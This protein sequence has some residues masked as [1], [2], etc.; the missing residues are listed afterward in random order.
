MSRAL[1]RVFVSAG[2]PSGDLHAAPV[3]EALR[4]LLPDV[5]VDAL[6]GPA[7]RQAGASIR[8]PMERYTVMGFFE[9][10]TKIHPHLRML[11]EL[12]ADFRADRYDLVVLVDYPG[13]NLRLAEAAHQAGIPTLYYIAPQLWA[14]R[15]GRA[16]RLGRSVDRLAAILPFEPEFFRGLGVPAEFVGHPLTERKWPSR[17]EARRTLGLDE[18]ERVLAVF[19][20]S[21]AQEVDRIWPVFREAAAGLLADGDCSRVLVA[22]TE[23]GSYPGAEQIDVRRTGSANLLAAADAALVKSGTT[24]LEA[25]MTGTPM[26]V[27]YRVN[28]LTAAIA[29]R[30]IRV[31]WIS[32]VNLVAERSVVPELL[33]TD[34]TPDRLAELVRPLLRREGPE[35]KAQCEGLAEVRRRLGQP[36]AAERVAAL[37]MELIAA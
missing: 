16:R 7:L 8:F 27:A 26:V 17:A 34:A 9:A 35:A 30:V 4:R 14:W 22:G 28:A 31:P 33:Q 29:R 21:R 15:P 13:F 5:E 12:R 24:T 1:P 3:V 36:G 32:L 18:A 10:L 6:G 37:A 20:G 2:E 23:A 25:A 11:R 19:P